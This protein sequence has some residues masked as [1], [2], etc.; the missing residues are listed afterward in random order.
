MI[1]AIEQVTRDGIRSA[2]MAA[3]V[4]DYIPGKR[5][6]GKLRSNA[7]S[8]TVEMEPTPKI[9]ARVN[10]ASGIK[11]GFKLEPSLDGTR[12]SEIVE[13]YFIP[14]KLSMLVVNQLKDVSATNHSAIVL[15]KSEDREKGFTSATVVGKE[16]L[17]MHIARHVSTRERAK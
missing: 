1:E 8:L 9:I 3:S 14:F 10:P 7:R 12:L 2:V 15:E 17:A 13:K 11:V 4:L 5:I 6:S 16:A